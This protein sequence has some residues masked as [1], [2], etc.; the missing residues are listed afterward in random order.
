MI[1]RPP[2]ST[3]FPYT[4]LFRSHSGFLFLVEVMV[5]GQGRVDAEMRAELLGVTGILGGNDAHF[6]ENA[7]RAERDV[8]QVPDRG[9]DNIEGAVH[10]SRAHPSLI[11]AAQPR[12]RYAK[13][14][15]WARGSRGHGPK[16]SSGPGDRRWDGDRSRDRSGFPPRRG[17]G[18]DRFG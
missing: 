11:G 10:G 9:A 17:S 1:R 16:G 3:L 15:T 18:D 13:M 7:Y 8:L 14:P 2:R 12:R 6:L 5:A 4:T